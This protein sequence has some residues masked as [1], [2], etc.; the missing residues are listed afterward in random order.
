MFALERLRGFSCGEEHHEIRPVLLRDA[1]H[2]PTRLF[3]TCSVP[4]V[5]SLVL[6]ASLTRN[7][8]S[9]LT[10]MLDLIALPPSPTTPTP[11]LAPPPTPSL[12]GTVDHTP[13]CAYLLFVNIH[14][15]ASHWLTSPTYFSYSPIASRIV[16]LLHTLSSGRDR[17]TAPPAQYLSCLPT[18]STAH[19]ISSGG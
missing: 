10:M 8:S 7:P 11:I 5:I 17:S 4:R 9:N 13:P 18:A 16:A 6:R 2:Q 19:I 15:H 14:I 3:G 1:T 12:C